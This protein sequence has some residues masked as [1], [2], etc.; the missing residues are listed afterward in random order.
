VWKFALASNDPDNL[1]GFERM[2]LLGSPSAIAAEKGNRDFKWLQSRQFTFGLTSLYAL[3]ALLSFL[4]WLRDRD[5]WLLFWMS[6]YAL[7]LTMDVVLIGLR[8]PL[9]LCDRSASRPRLPLQ[10]AKRRGGS[11]SSGCCNCISTPKAGVLH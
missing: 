6:L 11:C 10:F 4:A 2:P 9:S 7:M 8:L 1:G 5:Q 3:V